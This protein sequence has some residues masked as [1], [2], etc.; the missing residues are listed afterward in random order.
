MYRIAIV[1]S[2]DIIHSLRDLFHFAENFLLVFTAKNG[3][4]YLEKMQD[5]DDNEIPQVVLMDLIMP[6]MDG[7]KSII[8]SKLKYPQVKYI[9]LSSHDESDLLFKAIQAGANGYLLKDE[10]LSIIKEH[11][12]SLIN[13]E[14][15][16]MSP[17]IAKKTFELLHQVSNN[18]KEPLLHHN[19]EILS[20]LTQ[21][22]AEVLDLMT[23][24]LSYKKISELLFV[25]P[26][27]V[28]THIAH[29]YDKLHINS[30]VE[31]MNLLKR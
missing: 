17:S 30:K 18:V 19:N 3:I 8:L 26:N 28:R 25:S 9:V 29:I 13:N 14:A 5:L 16:P 27:T 1:D 4:D 2:R 10:K 6:E 31:M 15:T 23:K 22:E 7:I 20:V 11:I 24:G 12:I 21:R